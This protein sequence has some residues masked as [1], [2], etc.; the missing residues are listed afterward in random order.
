MIAKSPAAI[1]ALAKGDLA[2]FLVAETPGGI[3]AQEAAGQAALVRRSDLLPREISSRGIRAEDLELAW[4]IKYGDVFDD[5]FVN[6]TLPK[7]WLIEATDHA[8]HSKILDANGAIRAN[9]FYKAAFYDRRADIS[10][11]NR[12]RIEDTYGKTETSTD[13]RDYKA[14]TIIRTFG[15]AP[16]RDYDARNANHLAAEEW[17]KETYPDFANPLAYWSDEVVSKS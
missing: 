12:F 13:V 1:L 6:V 9:I 17:L 7:G 10:L 16:S 11:Q 8:M 14:D 2:N 4:G 15:A 5:L 3:E